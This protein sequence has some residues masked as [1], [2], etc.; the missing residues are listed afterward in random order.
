MFGKGA[1]LPMGE[2]NANKHHSSQAGRHGGGSSRLVR[3]D[4]NLSVP[5]VEVISTRSALDLERYRVGRKPKGGDH[6]TQR[7]SG[8]PRE[9][10]M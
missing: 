1:D 6:P 3:S 7:E 4:L 2:L 5:S 10:R 9:P 8:P